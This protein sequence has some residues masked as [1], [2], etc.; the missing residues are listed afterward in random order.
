M[1]MATVL[2]YNSAWDKIIMDK[3]F[4]NIMH[5]ECL[6][7]LWGRAKDE[8]E[9]VPTFVSVVRHQGG[10]IIEINCTGENA[11]VMYYYPENGE[12]AFG[13]TKEDMSRFNTEFGYYDE[14]LDE[15][16]KL[17]EIYLWV[18]SYAYIENVTYCDDHMRIVHSGGILSMHR[19]PHNRN[20]NF[21][22]KT[23][24]IN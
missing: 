21:I 9:G 16:S 5:N 23:S 11:G 17:K 12:F 22:T 8:I 18:S 13:K 20:G 24:Y 14:E 4:H 10:N 19:F 3:R 2:K 15:V 7:S 6:F 1:S